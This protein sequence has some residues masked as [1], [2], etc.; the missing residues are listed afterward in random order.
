[1][2]RH[3]AESARLRSGG[4][5]KAIHIGSAPAAYGVTP[6]ATPQANP[7]AHV[8]P[9]AANPY[10][11]P[12]PYAQANPYGQQAH[13]NAQAQN[14]GAQVGN[15]FS[16]FGNALSSFVDSAV[17]GFSVGARV[18]VQWS[19]GNRYPGTV[20]NVQSGQ[21]EVLFPDGRRVWVPQGY[22]NAIY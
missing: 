12:N 11:Q 17:G 20:T 3:T 4:H 16:A 9:Y 6:P 2:A 15:A 8:N 14:I 7:Y 22:V 18:A 5:P 13:S 21:V 1:M 10:A 19:D